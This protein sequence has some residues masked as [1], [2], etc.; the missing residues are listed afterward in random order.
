MLQN[1]IQL[2]DNGLIVIAMQH[3]E[4]VCIIMRN[5]AK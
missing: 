4:I 2:L 3:F 1:I 5:Y